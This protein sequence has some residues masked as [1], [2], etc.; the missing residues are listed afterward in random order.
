MKPDE[1]FW[2]LSDFQSWKQSFQEEMRFNPTAKRQ[3]VKINRA[4]LSRPA[5]F[6]LFQFAYGEKVVR[7][8]YEKNKNV[9]AAVKATEEKLDKAQKRRS[10][11]RFTMFARRAAD[12]LIALIKTPNPN[13]YSQREMYGELIEANPSLGSD[14]QDSAWRGEVIR[15]GGTKPLLFVLKDLAAEHGVCLGYTSLAALADAAD[16][17]TEHDRW[18]LIE[19]AQQEWVREAR[20]QWLAEFK[21]QAIQSE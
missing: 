5:E 11:Q 2:T 1:Q 9:A 10:D 15:R 17:S 7:K 16:P 19:F 18:S 6:L 8:Y 13:P 3:W 21:R 12:S 14:L 4:D 20:P